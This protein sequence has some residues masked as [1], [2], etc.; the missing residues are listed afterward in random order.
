MEKGKWNCFSLP[1]IC[2]QQFLKLAAESSLL[3]NFVLYIYPGIY[4]GNLPISLFQLVSAIIEVRQKK[5]KKKKNLPFIQRTN[6]VYGYR[7]SVL[8]QTMYM[9]LK[10]RIQKEINYLFSFL[11]LFFFFFFL[12]FIALCVGEQHPLNW[13]VFLLSYF[14]ITNSLVFLNIKRAQTYTWNKNCFP[15]RNF[16]GA[17]RV[18]FPSDYRV[19]PHTL[20]F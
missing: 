5:K 2:W 17:F 20:S 14:F 18:S 11:F 15:L 4:L 9:H 12:L 8:S 10:G 7:F 13:N 3:L 1:I 6:I 16:Q 19:F